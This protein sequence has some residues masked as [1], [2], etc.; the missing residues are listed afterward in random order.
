MRFRL[1]RD[2]AL[3]ASENGGGVKGK[4]GGQEPKSQLRLVRQSKRGN[5]M[6]LPECT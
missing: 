6:A 5:F 4:R 3:V 1:E 2:M